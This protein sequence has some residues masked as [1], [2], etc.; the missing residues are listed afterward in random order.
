MFKNSGKSHKKVILWG[1]PA[2]PFVG[3]TRSYLLKK[4]ID[5]QEIYSWHPRYHNEIAAR[6]GTF[7]IPVVELT[8][9]TLIQDST[10]TIVHFE[11][12][13]AEPCLIPRTP[14]QKAVAWLI[15]FFGSEMLFSAGMHY[16]WSFLNENRPFLVAEFARGPSVL[17]KE[18]QKEKVIQQMEYRIGY[19]DKFGVTPESIPVVEA[20]YEELLDLMEIHFHHYPYILGGR[21]SLADFGV[22]TFF[23]AHLARD[24]CPSRLMKTRAPNVFRWTE[25]M[26]E[27]GCVDGEF[28]DLEPDFLPDDRIP[29]TTERLLRHFFA[30]FSSEVMGLIENYNSWNNTN[31]GLPSG[32]AIQKDMD[33]DTVSPHPPLGWMEFETRG[34]KRRRIAHVD[35]VYHFQR[36][37]DVG[38][39]GCQR[40]NKG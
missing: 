19:L 7:V 4:G 12:S 28:P 36:V 29:E 2:S 38:G 23:F 39:S 21:P 15:G 32:A 18:K 14:V 10:D 22:I 34:V 37:L 6:I 3:K 35:V 30:D 1:V 27:K 31:S 13:V 20:S 11:N 9:G 17:S 40:T 16:R 5:F 33:S 26:F 25:R 24:I 8:D